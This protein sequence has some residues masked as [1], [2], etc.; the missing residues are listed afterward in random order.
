MD[1]I[2]SKNYHHTKIFL[3]FFFISSCIIFYAIL[4]LFLKIKIKINFHDVYNTL[5]IYITTMHK[6][7]VNII[8]IVLLF[9][10]ICYNLN[11][12]SNFLN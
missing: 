12:F 1:N 4:L 10:R 5:E 3:S 11:T 8:L 9:Y 2:A 7:I 6:C